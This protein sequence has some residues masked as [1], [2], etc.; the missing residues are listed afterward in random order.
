MKT[1]LKIIVTLLAGLGTVGFLQQYAQQK[2]GQPNGFT[3]RV[4]SIQLNSPNT[5]KL[6]ANSLYIIG[7]SKDSIYLGNHRQSGQILISSYKL[8]T[9]ETFWL[10]VPNNIQ[11]GWGAARIYKNDKGFFLVEGITPRIIQFSWIGTTGIVVNPGNNHFDLFVPLDSQ[12]VYRTY[13]TITHSN[14]IAYANFGER[15]IASPTL[16]VNQQDGV[17]STDGTLL[18]DNITRRFVYVYSYRN[19]LIAFNTMLS[20]VIRGHTIDTNSIAKI[21]FHEVK[22]EQSMIFSA[23]PVKPNRHAC[24][25]NGYLYI[26]SG[27]KADNEKGRVAIQSSPIDVYRI[28][29]FAYMG[30]FYVPNYDGKGIRDF[31]IDRDKLVALRGNEITIYK[32]PALPK[33]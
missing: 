7:L 11:F 1:V 15:G 29:D 19:Q 28:A 2:E 27:L 13:N 20:D 3:R 23:P 18:Y 10:D 14:Q 17:F 25:C 21:Q 24:A 31:A 4:F 30:S 32:I 22:S 26:Y 16:L 5:K 12:Y 9:I 8:N 33:P 6:D